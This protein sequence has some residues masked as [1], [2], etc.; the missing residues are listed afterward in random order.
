MSKN[1]NFKL[2]KIKKL[3]TAL[4]TEA[5]SQV[6][7][8]G[9]CHFIVLPG[10][11]IRVRQS[12]IPGDLLVMESNDRM[13][14]L[15]MPQRACDY[16]AVSAGVSEFHRRSTAG[17]SDSPVNSGFV[18]FQKKS[19]RDGLIS[20]LREEDLFKNSRYSLLKAKWA[21][22]RLNISARDKMNYAIA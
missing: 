1:V 2:G 21:D 11:K 4:F 7:E 8:N 19:H 18:A 3:V 14:G 12:V 22:G 13:F 9:Y 6:A 16:V 15:R 10:C 20:V 5:A 17:R